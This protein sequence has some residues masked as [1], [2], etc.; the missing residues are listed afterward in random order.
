MAVKHSASDLHLSTGLAPILRQ[1]GDLIV[2]ALPVL[3]ATEAESLIFAT[4]TEQQQAIFKTALDIDYAL[5]IPELS[6]FRVN[7]FMQQRG[8][9]AV[10]RPIKMQIPDVATLGLP[11]RAYD[12][13]V[14]LQHGLVLVT[15]P[16]GSGKS[17]TLAALID[18]INHRHARHIL[19]LEDPIE[20]IYTPIK[21]LINQR[22]VYRHTQSFDAA[23]RS[24]LRED[25]DVI[26]IGE[27]RDPQTIKLAL[28]AAETGHLVFG[29]LH[30]NA[31]SKT[32]HRIID[33]FSVD[34]KNVVRTMLSEALQ[35]VISQ[36][37]IKKIGGS[38]VAAFEIMFCNHAIRHLIRDDKLAQIQHVLQTHGKEGMQTMESHVKSLYEAGVISQA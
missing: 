21:S 18:A 33:V 16:T 32:I 13:L 9:A 29:T 34:E 19:T 31:S 36:R 25:P 6:R 10:F 2:Q 1:D 5:N 3:S 22:E 4:M 17:T 30:T 37:L 7:V 12:T 20:Y 23:L 38:R 14:T 28:T 26:L 27:L 8:I 24:G 15:G 35:A 11:I